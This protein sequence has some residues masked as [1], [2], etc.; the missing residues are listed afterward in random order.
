MS[1]QQRRI[2]KYSIPGRIQATL[3]ASFL[4]S[5]V[6]KWGKKDPVMLPIIQNSSI[7]QFCFSISIRSST[8]ISS[9]PIFTRIC[10]CSSLVRA[11]FLVRPI[12]VL[13]LFGTAA[14]AANMIS[15]I[16][17]GT[18]L[19]GILLRSILLVSFLPGLRVKLDLDTLLA[20]SRLL[21]ILKKA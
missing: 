11:S 17:Q 5:R 9:W 1:D 10:S 16:L 21:N 2:F 3:L 18:S 20:S 12:P 8:K 6:N 4:H 15:T 7:I 13:T 19:S 14:I